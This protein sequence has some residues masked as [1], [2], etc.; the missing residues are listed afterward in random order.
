MNDLSYRFVVNFILNRV[1]QAKALAV[2]ENTN[3]AVT[4]ELT[5]LFI[6][7]PLL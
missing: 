4:K 7:H 1:F 3:A 6:L 5:N 2:T